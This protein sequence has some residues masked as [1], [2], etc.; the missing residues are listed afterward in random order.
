MSA[1]EC[2]NQ[3]IKNRPCNSV[4]TRNSVGANCELN[5]KS[6]EDYFDNVMLSGAAGWVYRTTNYTD[7]NVSI[8]SI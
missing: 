4:N 2:E 3:C 8:I 1:D 5:S 7:R 6:T